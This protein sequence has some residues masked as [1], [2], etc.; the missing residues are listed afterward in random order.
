MRVFSGISMMWLV[1]AGLSGALCAVGMTW[2]YFHPPLPPLTA[3]QRMRFDIAQECARPHQKT[4]DTLQSADMY[5]TTKRVDYDA[6]A[7]E[8]KEISK[9]MAN[10]VR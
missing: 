8:E 3:G 7:S 2:S 5:K 4:L 6:I 1:L 10:V 9:C